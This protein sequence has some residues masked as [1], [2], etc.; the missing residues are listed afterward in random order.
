MKTKKEAKRLPIIFP[1]NL[2][3]FAETADGTAPHEIQVLPVGTWNHPGYGPIVITRED[4]A[5]FKANFDK[6]L[7][8]D[9][10]ITEG[11]E[12]M[13]EKPA[14]GWFKELIDRGANGLYAVVEW[15]EQGKTLLAEKSYKYFSPEFYSEYEDPETRVIHSNVLVGGA[16]T[17][18]PYF[19]ELDAVVMSEKF[20]KQLTFNENNTMNLQELLAK[21][22]EELTAEEKA[23][24]KEHAGELTDEQKDT[25]KTVLEETSEDAGTDDGA[26]SDDSKGDED[27]GAEND[28]GDEGADKGTD[29]ESGAGNDAGEAKVEGSEGVVIKNGKVEM[30]LAAFKTLETKANSGYEASET[31]RKSNIKSEA[32][33]L[34]FSEQNSNGRILPKHEVKVFTF[35]LGLSDKQRAEFSEIVTAIPATKLFSENGT[36]ASTEGTAFSEIDTKAKKLMSENKGMSYSDAV[37]GVVKANPE[38]ANRYEQELGK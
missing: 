10:P 14:V 9:I 33:K 30:S 28:K 17:N 19:K 34:V 18:K 37:N 38:L 22:A 25:F 4:I 21:K 20:L 27:K 15:T 11:H 1:I 16:L 7:R 13:D 23:F 29:N 5:E 31:L 32:S 6:G 36:G 26:G 24:V 35:M 12:V 3:A 8:R 2:R